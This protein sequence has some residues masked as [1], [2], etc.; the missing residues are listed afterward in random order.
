LQRRELNLLLLILVLAVVS[1]W[2]DLNPVLTINLFGVNK[3]IRVHE[4]LDLQGG[5]Q[6]L[7]QA[8]PGPSGPPSADQMAATR[9]IIE[10]RVNALGVTEPVVQVSGGDRIVVEL[11]G[12]REP[13]KAIQAFGQVG[14]LEII[15]TGSE[16]LPVGS[17]VTTT[18][19]GPGAAGGQSIPAPTATA[20]VGSTPAATATPET[21][22]TPGVG[23]SQQAT[24]SPSPS[25]SPTPQPK[26]YQTILT[27]ADIAN[28]E[29]TFDNLGRPQV[30]FEL[31]AEGAKK[32][33]D[34]TTQNVG[35]YLSILMDKRVIN[36]AV[37]RQPITQGRGVIEGLESLEEA[38]NVV[39]QL[40]Y[41]ALPVALEVKQISTVGPTLGQDSLRRSILAGV[42][43]VLAVMAF[44][45]VYYRV[46]GVVADLALIIYAAIVFAIFK[47]IPVTLTLAGV[48]GFILSVG[49]AVDANVLIFARMKEELRAGKP[50]LV[51]I[52]EGFNRAWPSIRDSNI[53]TLIT[54][55]ILFEFGSFLGTSI[56]KGFAITLAI[57]VLVSMFSAIVTTRTFLRIVEL[58]PLAEHSWLFAAGVPGGGRTAPA[59]RRPE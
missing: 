28:A 27:G 54:C 42:I 14:F 13:E 18:L 22:A 5:M 21:A 44:M 34:F 15:S 26:V 46:P 19:G 11:P 45:A 31:K 9:D 56:V 1:L 23:V 29:V 3:E 24:A 57:G 6:V 51:A 37:I 7:L 39:L 30:S 40:K 2:I 50:L 25:P 20:T 10:Q 43:G 53:T 17:V 32:F 16:A 4:G 36:S 52:S 35:T 41:G 49:M 38:R 48:A 55:A 33:A 12:I 58:T 59:V 47:T 8:K